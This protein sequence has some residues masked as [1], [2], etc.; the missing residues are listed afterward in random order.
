MWVWIIT[1]SPSSIS[2]CCSAMSP[3]QSV[4][5]QTLPSLT[6]ACKLFSKYC[7][8]GIALVP[9]RENW[10]LIT[11]NPVCGWSWSHSV[12]VILPVIY[13][14]LL[15][16]KRCTDGA[17][18]RMIPQQ[19]LFE[20]LFNVKCD[21]CLGGTV[22]EAKKSRSLFLLHVLWISIKKRALE[23]HIHVGKIVC[24]HSHTKHGAT[25][26]LHV[27]G[28]WNRHRGLWLGHTICFALDMW[29]GI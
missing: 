8:I 23:P 4:P 22:L 27:C 16:W 5:S 26:G 13:C 1:Y 7:P 11:A 20:W 10:L 19:T 14:L 3:L 21:K 24:A 29:L 9:V 25:Q 17:L 15:Q 18:C 28:K 6:D 12:C 2:Q